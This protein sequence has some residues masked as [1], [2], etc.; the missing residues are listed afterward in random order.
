[1]PGQVQML[2]LVRGVNPK[3]EGSKKNENASNLNIVVEVKLV[4]KIPISFPTGNS[5]PGRCG[6]SGAIFWGH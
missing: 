4:K 1:M 6:V 3:M 5:W 2:E